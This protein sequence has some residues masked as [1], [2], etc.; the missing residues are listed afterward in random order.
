MMKTAKAIERDIFNI[1]KKSPIGSTIKGTVYRKG[2]RPQN[3]DTEDIVVK[4]LAGIDEQV[5]NGVVIVNIYVSDVL[6]KG[7]SEKVED[8]KRI[9]LFQGLANN[10]VET[11]ENTEYEFEKD[12]T[13]VSLEAEGIEQHFVNLRLKF[14]RITI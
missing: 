13:P 12:G 8:S 3:V 1:I 11:L 14:K 7:R 4:F 5:Q 2:I 10:L 6:L 9:E